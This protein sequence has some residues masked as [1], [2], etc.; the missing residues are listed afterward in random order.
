MNLA[1]AIC[2]KKQQHRNAKSYF[3]PVQS[4]VLMVFSQSDIGNPNSIIQ[5]C[6][7][8][9]ITVYFAIIKCQVT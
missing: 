8:I 4:R 6:H 9:A 2:A 7:A 5:F 3:F 1:K